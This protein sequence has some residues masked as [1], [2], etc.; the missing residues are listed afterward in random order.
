MSYTLADEPQP[1]GLQHLVVNPLWP[2]F[3]FMFGGA[4]LAFP[5]YVF[6]GFAMGS[7]TRKREAAVA[8]ATL[9]LAFSVFGM[10]SWFESD[11]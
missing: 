10:L 3:G 2:L 8:G 11:M 6:N 1:S 7:P 9:M 4:W 5:W